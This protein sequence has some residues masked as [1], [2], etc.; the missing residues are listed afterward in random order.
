MY[1][2]L[3]CYR[4]YHTWFYKK[5]T[6]L[7]CYWLGDRKSIRPVKKTE[8]WGDDVV[9]CL[10]RSAGLHITQMMPLPLTVSCSSKSRQAL[11]FWY[12][13]TRVV[14]DSGPLN[15]YLT[16]WYIL[17]HSK[18]KGH[19]KEYLHNLSI[20]FANTVPTS[21]VELSSLSRKG[22]QPWLRHARRHSAGVYYG[23]W[24]HVSPAGGDLAGGR[25][26]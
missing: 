25:R 22:Y 9:I 6:L 23:R 12:Q 14:P 10:R 8:W 13:L 15:R 16:L 3:C 1:I 5:I 7:W 19:E 2:K 26:E 18:Q 20:T 17:Q 21:E 24:T 4:H 11:P